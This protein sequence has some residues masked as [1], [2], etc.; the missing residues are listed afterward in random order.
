MA[1]R[2]VRLVTAVDPSAVPRACLSAV[3]NPLRESARRA[4]AAA[5]RLTAG[6]APR[7]HFAQE[8]LLAGRTIS[9]P[10]PSP[11]T[12]HPEPEGRDAHSA[13]NDMLSAPGLLHRDEHARERRRSERARDQGRRAEECA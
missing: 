1:G 9:L 3:A 8:G 13:G 7:E 5:R 10:R 11:A 2:G 4:R 6:W 12:R